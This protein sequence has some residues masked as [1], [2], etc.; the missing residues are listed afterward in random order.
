[1]RAAELRSRTLNERD[2]ARDMRA[3]GREVLAAYASALGEKLPR[4][5]RGELLRLFAEAAES[6]ARLTEGEEE[7]P[8]RDAFAAFSC[9]RKQLGK[10][11]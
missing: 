5:L 7:R 9:R 4:G 6:C 8:P 2:A 11:E 1:M 3:C 10:Q